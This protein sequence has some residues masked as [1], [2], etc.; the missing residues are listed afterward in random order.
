MFD[1]H[2]EDSIFQLCLQS[3]L[4]NYLITV[5]HIS[6]GPTLKR[7]VINYTVGSNISLCTKYFNSPELFG[8]SNCGKLIQQNFCAS[9]LYIH[10]CNYE[11]I[12][13]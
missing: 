5:S 13:I 3:P 10:R 9:K 6:S 1:T 7:P 2:G 8:D 12:K 11:T 4:C